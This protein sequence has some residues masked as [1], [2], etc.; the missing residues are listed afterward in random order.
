MATQLKHTDFTP[1]AAP[2]PNIRV[3][4]SAGPA[5]LAMREKLAEVPGA[6]STFDELALQSLTRKLLKMA[7]DHLSPGMHEAF[8]CWG[9]ESIRFNTRITNDDEL[10]AQSRRYDYTLYALNQTKAQTIGDICLK[11]YV[12][13][14]ESHDRGGVFGPIDVD[15]REGWA[16]GGAKLASGFIADILSMSPLVFRLNEV[17]AKAWEMSG[18]GSGWT[19]EVGLPLADLFAEAATPAAVSLHEWDKAYTG[20]Q[21]AMAAFHACPEEPYAEFDRVVSA[22]ANATLKVMTTPAPTLVEFRVKTAL[23]AQTRADELGEDGQV[24]AAF[25]ADVRRLLPE[26]IA[27]ENGAWVEATA[28]WQAVR[29]ALMTKGLTDEQVDAL[30]EREMQAFGKLVDLPLRSIGDGATK[31]RAMIDLFG[32]VPPDPL[33]ELLAEMTRLSL[34]QSEGDD[35]TILDAFA[36]RRRQ[37]AENHAVIL[38]ADAE[39]AY[40]ARLDGNDETLLNTP[41]NTAA[42][43]LA[44][45]RVAFTQLEPN[46]WSDQAI[47]DPACAEFREGLPMGDMYVRMLWSGIEDLARIGGV[48]L[49]EQ[50]K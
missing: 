16:F 42:G 28:E 5:A 50:A 27:D 4:F 45:L 46:A 6:D 12:A 23:L 36:D 33:T 31:L 14:V 10:D 24:I 34:T 37:F 17:A 9:M 49:S 40:F 22:S 39:D 41:A 38:T 20:Y 21:E 15:H 29:Q 48:N 13:A 44:K 2:R 18:P 25:A 1:Q 30:V 3:V 8:L 35:R 19:Q 32:H 7:R 26:P 43:V 11:S 47:G